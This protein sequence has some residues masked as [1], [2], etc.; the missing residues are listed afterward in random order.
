M[1]ETETTQII[2]SDRPLIGLMGQFGSGMDALKFYAGK[3]THHFRQ[4]AVGAQQCCCCERKSASRVQMF[5]WRALVNP[6]FAFTR[7]DALLLLAGRVGMTLQHTV[8]DFATFHGLCDSCASNAKRNRFVSVVVKSIS[9]FLLLVCMGFI[10]FAGGAAIM[11]WSDPKDRHE[12]LIGFFIGVIGLIASVFGHKWER[13][14]RIPKFA[15]TI[16]RK[17][18]FLVKVMDCNNGGAN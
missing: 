3:M 7:T 2:E 10:V 8:V 6:R 16:G 5:C 11:F 12:F 15:R 18:F 14:L 13:N 1:N 9:F 17:P 4:D